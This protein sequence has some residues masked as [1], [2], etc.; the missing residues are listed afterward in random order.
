[1]KKYTWKPA[2]IENFPHVFVSRF[3]LIRY[4]NNQGQF[5]DSLG[6]PNSN[7]IYQ[8]TIKNPEGIQKK[9][10]VH[11]LVGNC[12]VPKVY[13]GFNI[14]SHKNNNLS[15][16]RASNLMWSDRVLVNTRK[17]KK[18]SFL[19]NRDGLYS[20]RFI[21]DGTTYKIKNQK[22]YEDLKNE[23]WRLRTDLVSQYYS[24]H[25]DFD[26]YIKEFK[27]EQDE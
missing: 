20:S 21:F 13:T 24:D 14:L 15:D 7:N 12:F 19:K 23:I 1:M 17:I 18:I 27:Y 6:T 8:V 9:F 16:N 10:C 3:G 22:S 5:C 11:K 4:L 26:K 2:N 25:F